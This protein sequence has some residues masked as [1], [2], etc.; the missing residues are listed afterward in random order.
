[1]DQV[2][3]VD[4]MAYIFRAFYSQSSSGVSPD[5][6]PT[7]ASFGFLDFL[8]RL[9]SRDNPSHIAVAFDSGPKTFRNEIYPDYKANRDETP[10]DL[11]P[12]FEHC[13]RLTR[14]LGMPLFKIDNHE[15]DD[16]IA[17]LAEL[18]REAGH[19]VTIISG[20]KDMAQLVT[21]QVKVMDPSR[22]RRFTMRTVPTRFGVRP[23]QMVDFLSL[24]GDASD[25]VPGVRGVGP[26]TACALL[27][28]LDSLDGIYANLSQ[29]PELPIRGAKTL[30]EKLE[31][32][33]REAYLS[34]ELVTLKRDLELG[35][36]PGDLEYTGAERDECETLFAELGFTH[37]LPF[38]AKWH[39]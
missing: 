27:E 23:D 6:V 16:V 20:D 5:G 24:T 34:K 19:P 10:P 26:K 3:I 9:L 12:Q 8:I 11:L 18:C 21:D 7:G 13:E 2:F 15:A 31:A 14:A 30:P 29:V 17:S 36:A 1:M 25:N 39:E 35:V 28:A 32:H 38:V 37:I 4:A 33:R 22:N